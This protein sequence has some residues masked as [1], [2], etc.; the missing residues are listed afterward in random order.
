MG[1][2]ST[3]VLMTRALYHHL[4]TV[5]ENQN[6][7]HFTILQAKGDKKTWKIIRVL[8]TKIFGKSQLLNG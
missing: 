5:F 6:L 3:N 7:T 1:L 2:C 8:Y 4:V